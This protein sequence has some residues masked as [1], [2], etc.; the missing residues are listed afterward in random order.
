M[1]YPSLQASDYWRRNKIAFEKRLKEL[2]IDY[3]IDIIETSTSLNSIKKDKFI[4]KITKSKY[5]FL[6]TTLNSNLEKNLIRKVLVYTDIKVVLQNITT[7][8]KEWEKQQVLTYVGFDYKIGSLKIADYFLKKFKVGN[9]AVMFHTQGYVSQMRGDTFI[10]YINN[11]SKLKLYD[12]YYT[13]GDQEKARL[14]TLDLLK[15]TK[16]IK[17][18]YACSTDIAIG[19]SKALQSLGLKDKILLNGWGGGSKELNMLKTKKLDT[20]IM[21]I[22][23]DAG[24]VM[25]EIIKGVILKDTIPKIFSG[26]MVLIDNN[27]SKEEIELLIKKSFRYSD[28]CN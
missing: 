4:D 9:Y 6:I 16:D 7:P 22:N 3:S 15:N 14:A 27:I 11:N 19:V 13:Q 10:N 23:D 24:I 20:T 5:D 26:E 28:E 2:K 1:L 18:I 8:I 25:A 12:S 17:F 21:R